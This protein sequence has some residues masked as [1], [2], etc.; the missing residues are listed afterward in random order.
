L[1]LCLGVSTVWNAGFL[2]PS[3]G[4][5][6]EW[7]AW[8]PKRPTLI[9][10]DEVQQRS[11]EAKTI[12]E[13]LGLR[14]EGLSNKVRVLL[15]GR[16]RS[17]ELEKLF[18]VD[19]YEWE[20]DFEAS[21]FS[22]PLAMDALSEKQAAAIVQHL[23]PGY[24]RFSE[25]TEHN[26][27]LWL[28][29]FAVLTGMAARETGQA[30]RWDQKTVTRFILERD[31]NQYWQDCTLED[32]NLLA[33]LAVAGRRPLNLLARDDATKL[34]PRDPRTALEH[35]RLIVG[36]DGP[37]LMPLDPMPLSELFVLNL[38]TETPLPESTE[39][40]GHKVME[41]AMQIQIAS[42]D[43]VLDTLNNYPDHPGMPR[44][45]AMMIPSFDRSSSMVLPLGIPILMDSIGDLV[46]SGQTASAKAFAK[47]AFLLERRNYSEILIWG[48]WAT[49]T[50]NLISALAEVGSFQEA[51]LSLE[52][53]ERNAQDEASFEFLGKAYTNT[54]ISAARWEQKAVAWSLA[55]KSL[56]LASS[57]PETSTFVAGALLDG[58]KAA[59]TVSD[60]ERMF[61]S[62]LNI[63]STSTQK[64]GFF[65]DV[66]R[67]AG[68]VANRAQRDGQLGASFGIFSAIASSVRQLE[69]GMVPAHLV[70]RLAVPAGAAAPSLSEQQ[71]CDFREFLKALAEEH[72]WND[73]VR[74]FSM[75]ALYNVV[76][77][78]SRKPGGAAAEMAFGAFVS[79]CEVG[80][81]QPKWESAEN[82]CLAAAYNLLSNSIDENLGRRVRKEL[83]L[84]LPNVLTP[85]FLASQ[86]ENWGA[87]PSVFAAFSVKL[88]GRTNGSSPT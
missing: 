42:T 41:L 76:N 38:L 69:P 58:V 75:H 27:G 80:A 62:A 34:F 12:L 35:N 22:T 88:L 28:P 54:V 47:A 82:N 50:F 71:V 13:T 68:N 77:T 17:K 37:E 25:M 26:S 33:Y 16:S 48:G 65:E 70:A 56:A 83:E 30:Y 60:A 36:H 1:E 4:F 81:M 32:E 55:E 44:L 51:V 85:E 79:M 52:E 66:V 72:A 43:F 14:G 5:L 19:P 2:P 78:L 67:L 63:W 49:A 8:Q 29:L 11:S 74:R 40:R 73:E 9:V 24:S 7:R 59:P 21:A 20:V 45:L 39:D 18:N 84:R 6:N 53:F 87:D 64:N 57:R 15:V 23:A 3:N 10:I 46:R 31:R 61:R 86:L